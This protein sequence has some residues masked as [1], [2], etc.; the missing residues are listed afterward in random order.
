MSLS[1]VSSRS[2]PRIP[3]PLPNL[4][5]GEIV[6]W[7]SCSNGEKRIQG[8]FSRKLDEEWGVVKQQKMRYPQIIALSRLNR[9]RTVPTLCGPGVLA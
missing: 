7:K 9:P 2:E 1:L 5:K 6:E 4:V 3:I 8:V